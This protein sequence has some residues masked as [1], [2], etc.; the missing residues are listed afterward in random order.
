MIVLIL[1]STMS[2]INSRPLKP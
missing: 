2:F 1:I